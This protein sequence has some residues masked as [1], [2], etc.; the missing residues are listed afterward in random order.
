MLNEIRGLGVVF[1]AVGL[2]WSEPASALRLTI[3]NRT[4][5]NP[6]FQAQ[7]DSAADAMEDQ[8]NSTIGASSQVED[9]LGAVGAANATSG[10]SLLSPGVHQQS[11][12]MVSFGATGALGLGAG[13]SL[14]N[15]LSIP[16]NRL[17]PIG[18][19]ART[20][21]T[22]AVS[23]RTLRSPFRGLDPNRLMTH[24]S[25]FTMD[26][27]PY[28]GRGISLKAMQAAVGMSYEVFGPK[29]WTPLL[30]YNG[31]R[32]STGLSYGTF[33]ASYQTPFDLTQSSG[34]LTARWDND[35]DIGVSS[36][37]F[38]LATEAVTGFRF[39]WALNLY[40]GLGVD[41]NFGSTSI[42]GGSSGPVTGTVAGTQVFSATGTVSTEDSDSAAPP[43]AQARFLLGT[44]IDLGNFGVYVQGTV[45]TPSVYAVS[46]GARAAF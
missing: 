43:L 1:L 22:V 38:S 44:Q 42:T 2:A 30:R 8:F 18:V 26:L 5:A 23:G 10:R 32:L 3:G 39:L 37:V 36:K 33:D 6:A 24:F 7:A 35:V 11:N 12:L 13:A 17:P 31:I 9:F 4:Y 21:L 45:S 25:F 19:G 16:S 20:A 46:L 14:S 34:G 41:F 28:I 15:G 40:A 29:P 27:S